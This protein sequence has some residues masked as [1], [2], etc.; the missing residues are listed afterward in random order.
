MSRRKGRL[1]AFQALYAWEVTAAPLDKLLE[2]NWPQT[3]DS[4][5]K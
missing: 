2:F 4:G 5:E 1:V 3:E